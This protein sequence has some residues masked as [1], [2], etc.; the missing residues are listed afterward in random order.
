M[1]SRQRSRGCAT[2]NLSEAKSVLDVGCGIR[3]QRLVKA[4]RYVGVDIHQ[5]YLDV[6]GGG[7]FICS[8]WRPALKRF[9]RH[10]FD[11]VIALDFI[12]HLT[13]RDGWDFLRAAQRVGKLVCIFTP[14]GPF[15]QHYE[16]GEPDAWGMDGGKWQTHRS[17][18]T[19]EDFEGWKVTTWPAF[20]RVNAVGAALPE[21]IDAFWA[22][23]ETDA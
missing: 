17:A 14:S 6:L 11:A 3:P 16:E 13:R 5:P 7:E 4:E 1:A 23:K 18:W 20:H 9:K 19:P 12:E 15:P 10:E 8:D 22:K 2:V 21:P